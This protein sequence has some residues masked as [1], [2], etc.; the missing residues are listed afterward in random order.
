MKKGS[1]G[2]AC[3]AAGPLK[4]CSWTFF[5]LGSSGLAPKSTAKEAGRRVGAQDARGKCVKCG[6]IGETGPL[7]RIGT[8]LG[9]IKIAC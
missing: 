8:T 6:R 5:N 2:P 3:L 9:V 7:D 1:E 4:F